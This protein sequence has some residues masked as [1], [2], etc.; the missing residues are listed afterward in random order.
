MQ[1]FREKT[2]S[3]DFV[4]SQ[5]RCL[6]WRVEEGRSAF[7]VMLTHPLVRRIT[8][9][10]MKKSREIYRNVILQQLSNKKDYARMHKLMQIDNINKSRILSYS[11]QLSDSF[12]EMKIQ[13][14]MVYKKV[15][16]TFKDIPQVGFIEIERHRQKY[17]EKV[18]YVE[19]KGFEIEK[20][21]QT[22][23]LVNLVKE[24]KLSL[25]MHSF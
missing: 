24:W 14:V 8:G 22:H 1:V 18:E 16:Y 3:L 7:L 20:I 15:K 4:K 21:E 23:L 5:E 25:H 11:R 13:S 10:E 2:K 17:R 19:R 6:E 12:G 9:K